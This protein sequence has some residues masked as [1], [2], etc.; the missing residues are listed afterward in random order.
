MRQE[1]S[2]EHGNDVDMFARLPLHRPTA[3]EYTTYSQLCIRWMYLGKMLVS[4]RAKQ[5]PSSTAVV[6]AASAC[7]QPSSSRL[8]ATCVQS[9]TTFSVYLPMKGPHFDSLKYAA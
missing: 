6:S 2:V 9:N 8:R 1:D 4:R 3:V 5:M 7:E